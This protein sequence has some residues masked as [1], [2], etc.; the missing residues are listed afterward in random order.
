MPVYNLLGYSIKHSKKSESLWQYFGS[1]KF[2]IKITGSATDN[3][4][5]H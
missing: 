5:V 2:K 4:K 3:L 1:F